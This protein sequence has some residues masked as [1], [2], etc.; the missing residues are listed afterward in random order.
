[1]SHPFFIIELKSDFSLDDCIDFINSVTENGNKVFRNLFVAL[2]FLRLKEM[3]GAFPMS[4]ITFGTALMNN[5]DPGSFTAV[6]AG[7]MIK[8]AKGQFTLIGSAYER[9]RLGLSDEQLKNKLQEAAQSELKTIFC[10]GGGKEI[11]EEALFQQL[12]LLKESKVI[13]NDLHPT[14]IYELPFQNFQSY[15]PNEEELNTAANLIKNGLEKVFT[16][17]FAILVALPSDLIGFSSLMEALPFDGAFFIKSGTYPHAIHD[18]TIKL[19]HVHC[20]E[21]P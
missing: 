21:K 7:K 1:M 2:P 5:A 4:G 19:V 8:E 10:V 16:Q 20:E 9:N 13:E 11:G 18:E 17:K 6:V 12:E 14:L 3:T 15:L